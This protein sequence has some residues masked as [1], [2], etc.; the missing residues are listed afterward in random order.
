VNLL[1]CYIIHV[2]LISFQTILRNS[3]LSSL[4]DRGIRLR[5]SVAEKQAKLKKLKDLWQ[6][7]NFDAVPGKCRLSKTKV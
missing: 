3:N 2:L 1:Q 6:S 4:P 5:M 7:L